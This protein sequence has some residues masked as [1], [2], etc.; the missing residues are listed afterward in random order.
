MALIDQVRTVC[1]RLVPLGWRPF[2]KAATSNSLDI[3]KTTTAALRTELTK[4]L[5]AINRTIPGLE[6]FANGGARAVTAAQ[7]SLSVLYHALAI[8]LIMRDHLGLPFGGFATPAELDALENFIFS[9]APVSLPQF[10]A[11]NGGTTKVAVVDF[12]S[13]YRPAADT[14]DGRH[15]DWDWLAP[16]GDGRCVWVKL[17]ST[18]DGDGIDYAWRIFRECAGTGYFLLGDAA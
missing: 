7:P 6:D 1:E 15:A 2:L 11:Q 8:P 3:H 18:S 9:L 16:L 4:N 17:R 10:I 5:P 14:V 13:E 12:S